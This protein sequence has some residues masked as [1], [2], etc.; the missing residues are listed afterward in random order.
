MSL[1]RV[2]IPLKSVQII[3]SALPD[4]ASTEAKQDDAISELQDIENQIIESNSRSV[5]RGG[6]SL[7]STYDQHSHQMLKQIL[8]QLQM[9]NLHLYAMTEEDFSD[10]D[11]K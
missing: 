11:L 10:S 2:D 1:D 3:E 7:S 5:T 4:G 8:H 6:E 9:M